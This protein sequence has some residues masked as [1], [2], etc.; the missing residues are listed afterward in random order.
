M[1]GFS[2]AIQRWEDEGGALEQR[3]AM[4][5]PSFLG[6]RD[7][8][9]MRQRRITERLTRTRM[10]RFAWFVGLGLVVLVLLNISGLLDSGH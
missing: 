3:P 7:G 9:T 2:F 5:L 4:P 10:E 6:R 8:A 1:Q